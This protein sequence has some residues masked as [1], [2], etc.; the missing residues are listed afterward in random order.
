[1]RILDMK[2]K[3]ASVV[4]I[5]CVL[6]VVITLPGFQAVSGAQVV[7]LNPPSG[8]IQRTLFGMHIHH[9]VTGAPH[10]TAWPDVPFGSWRIWDAYVSWFDVQPR[11]GEWDFKKLDS[12]IDL[13]QQHGVDV[14]LPLAMSPPWAS[15]NPGGSYQGHTAPPK[16]MNDWRNYVRTVGTRYKGRIH[17]YE[18]WNE[19]NLDH[20]YSG[21]MGQMV[22]L[23]REASQIL[24]EIDPSIRIVSP[25]GTG[26]SSGTSWLDAFLS[27]GGGQYVDVIGFHF[28]VNP[29][30][31]ES[32]VDLIRKVRSIMAK[33]G[34][35]TKYIWDTES[36]WAVP[37]PFP[38]A[39][40]AAAYVARAYV[41][42]WAASV[43]RFFWYSWDNQKYGLQLTEAD[44]NTLTPAGKAYAQVENWLE[45]A[46]M[47]SC[48]SDASGTWTSAITQAS[49]SR[50]WIVWN[51]THSTSF[52]IPEQWNVTQVKDL[53]GNSRSVGSKVLDIG[54]SP[55]LLVSAGKG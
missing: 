42:H 43:S 51:S 15:S 22:A 36:G 29:N 55:L 40:Q 18:I 26:S 39:E 33:H 46:L 31:P 37:N 25:S 1:M 20:Y 6:G 2:L 5:F 16:D 44:N 27:N 8:V 11:R 32:V 38:S 13:A 12:Y 48:S 35:E 53:S 45:G 3:A 30:P 23:T 19:P 14:L 52:R 21:N 28:Y 17:N 10:N 9:F 4:N 47:T 50:S 49:G 24:K 34:I 7:R 54:V 41:L